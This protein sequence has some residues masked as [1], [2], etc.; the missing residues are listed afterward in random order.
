MLE[1]TKASRW[2]PYGAKPQTRGWLRSFA[3]ACTRPIAIWAD[4]ARQRRTLAN[5]DDHMLRDIGITRGQARRECARS[6]WR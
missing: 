6:F 1:V 3:F 5:L 4:R 2:V